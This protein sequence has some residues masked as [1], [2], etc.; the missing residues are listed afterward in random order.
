MWN[1]PPRASCGCER[2]QD[3]DVIDL[4]PT[5]APQRTD[6]ARAG[7]LQT[8]GRELART[9]RVG[10]HIVSEV[11]GDKRRVFILS[12]VERSLEV[13]RCEDCKKIGARAV[14]GSGHQF[15]FEDS[16]MGNIL[17]GD[18]VFKVK[19]LELINNAAAGGSWPSARRALSVIS[20]A[21]PCTTCCHLRSNLTFTHLP[22]L[23][24]PTMVSP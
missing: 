21:L 20:F 2:L 8:H 7:R 6:T 18:T 1:I 19:R 12:K 22:T 3:E 15:V 5:P 4:D 24:T 14:C 11:Y 23:R 9:V 13:Q 17:C 16:Y 10:D